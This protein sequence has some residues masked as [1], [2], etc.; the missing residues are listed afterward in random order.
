[1]NELMNGAKSAQMGDFVVRIL[2]HQHHTWQGTI[3]WI[4]R[5]K[6]IVFRSTLELIMLM[7]SAVR[8]DGTGWENAKDKPTSFD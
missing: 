8:G 5:E 2:N 1:M 4:G 7:D 3:T 6:E